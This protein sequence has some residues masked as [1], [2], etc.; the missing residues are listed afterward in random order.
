V[1]IN[2]SESK[3]LALLPTSLVSLIAHSSKHLRRIFPRG[4]RIGSSNFDPL[5]FWRNGSQVASLNWQVYD[6]GMQVNEAMFV[7]S[8]GWVAKPRH[9]RTGDPE[10]TKPPGGREKLV[11]EIVGVSSCTYL[12]PFLFASSSKLDECSLVPA[13]NGR[14]GKTFS[15]YVRAQL[16][17]ASGDLE[18]RSKSIK[19]QHSIETGANVIWQSQFEWEYENDEM[20]FLRY[21]HLLRPI[22]RH[23][24]IALFFT[25]DF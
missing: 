24:L 12:F 9:M 1:L 3:C 15:T 23:I 6:R 11:G 16:F 18:W 4:T 21:M 2:I 17:H 25:T 14:T 19:T 8:P 5:T 7:G 20:A 13:P 22:F 10:E